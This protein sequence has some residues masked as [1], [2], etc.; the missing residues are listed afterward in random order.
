MVT[1]KKHARKQH[2]KKLLVEQQRQRVE[3]VDEDE[4]LDNKDL[5]RVV[6]PK[7]ERN[8]SD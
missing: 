5:M 4:A 1:D 8:W 2:K 6:K 3:D 7:E